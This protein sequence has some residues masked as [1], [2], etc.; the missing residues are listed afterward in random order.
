MWAGRVGACHG[1]GI[2]ERKVKRH[3]LSFLL[4]DS[5]TKTVNAQ[6]THSLGA[7]DAAE[8]VTSAC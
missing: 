7:A 3:F 1:N 2:I 5:G 6:Q 8:V 4:K